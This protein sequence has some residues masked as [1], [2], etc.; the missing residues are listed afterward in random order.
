[1]DTTVYCNKNNKKIILEKF[2]PSYFVK[3]KVLLISK[4]IF[5]SWI[6]EYVDFIWESR[7]SS[8]LGIWICGYNWF[9]V[10]PWKIILHRK[11]F[12]STLYTG[13]NKECH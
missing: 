2:T 6:V 13:R 4:K 7:V 11:F 12:Y 10:K 1:M 9:W 5:V 3:I 8:L